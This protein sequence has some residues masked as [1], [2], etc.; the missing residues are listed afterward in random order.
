MQRSSASTGE[1]RLQAV[2]LDV[3]G[4]LVDSERDGHRVAFNRAFEEA[5]L[6]DCWDV[7]RYGELLEITGGDRRI[8]AHLEQRGMPEDERSELAGRLHARKTE[9]FTEMAK[10]GEI[11]PRPGVDELLDELEREGVRLA[12]A[13]T[14]SA[15]WV[16]PLLER[17]FGAERFKPIVTSE[18]AP[19]R[20]PD[21]S[22]HRMALEGLG[23]PEFAAP[24][25]EDSL[26]GLRA[27][28]SAGLSCVVVVNDYTYEQDFNDADLV[29]DGFGGSEG[30]ASV[31]A[32][33]HGLDPPGRLDVQTLRRL[34]A[35]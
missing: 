20:K 23:L 1:D 10:R 19:E 30:P 5:G 22:A 2:V 8:N 26:N 13:T 7:E 28:K 27:A 12:V 17:L 4:T 6:S 15:A 32:D 18:E 9:I 29:L 21:P 3:D 33:P 14:G 24:A 34:T 35:I 25:I 31:L 16:H 11:K